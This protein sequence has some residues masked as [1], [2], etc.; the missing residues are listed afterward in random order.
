MQEEF[1]TVDNNRIRYLKAGA[2]KRNLVLIHG[3]GASAERWDL[4]MPTFAKNFT[5]YVP[6]LIGFGFSDKP[7]TD[8]TTEFFSKF[9]ASFLSELGIKKAI[10][11]GSS[12]GGQIAAEFASSNPQIV[13]KLILVS[14]AGVMKQ[15][16]P[17][18]DAYI[19]AAMYPDPDSAKNAFA[20]MA[21][22]NKD[23]SQTI[24]DG[25]IQRML[26]PN[27]KYAFLSTILGLKNS[28]EITPKLELI[29]IPT[30]V[31]WGDMDPVIPIKYADYFVQKIRDCRFYQ[32]ANSGHTPYVED[33]KEFIRIVLEFLK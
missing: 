7:I 1:V 3:L 31:I 25:F 12:L 30:L 14:P 20:M 5:V 26:M 13:D 9:L 15:S 33:P 2:S 10:I 18:L 8:Y 29:E 19:M 28:P 17:A 24:V 27:A 21:G 4:V 32:I 22:S 23:V 16:T 6:D 11:I